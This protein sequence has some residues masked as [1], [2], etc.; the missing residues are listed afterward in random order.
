MDYAESTKVVMRSRLR[1]L[2]KALPLVTQEKDRLMIAAEIDMLLTKLGM[3]LGSRELE[4]ALQR[5]PGRQ[6]FR[7]DIGEIKKGYEGTQVG[8]SEESLGEMMKMAEEAR[9]PNEEADKLKWTPGTPEFAAREERAKK[10][11]EEAAKKPTDE[12]PQA[13]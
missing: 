10:R 1:K 3:Q 13:G 4:I 5:G 7:A 12:P 11:V 2:F 8:V 6:R 9:L